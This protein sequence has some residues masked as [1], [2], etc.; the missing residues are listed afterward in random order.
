[1]IVIKFDF[2]IFWKM[3]KR[4]RGFLFQIGV[5]YC[6]Q[7]L[8][9]PGYRH[10]A[11]IPWRTETSGRSVKPSRRYYTDLIINDQPSCIMDLKLIFEVD[12]ARRLLRDL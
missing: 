2:R 7:L 3:N 11:F 9:C 5:L 8:N 10:C 6:F 4:R 1:M 12:D